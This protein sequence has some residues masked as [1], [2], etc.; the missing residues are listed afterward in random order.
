MWTHTQNQA[1]SKANVDALAKE[2][3]GYLERVS[4]DKHVYIHWK[5]LELY[6]RA[7]SRI[8]TVEHHWLIV[9][10]ITKSDYARAFLDREFCKKY[11]NRHKKAT[12]F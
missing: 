2:V 4:G 1:T 8:I 9:A 10:N 12:P 7:W 11:P 5:A 6:K 3:E